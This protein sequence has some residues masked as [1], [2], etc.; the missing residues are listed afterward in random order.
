ML[1]GYF[2]SLKEGWVVDSILPH[3]DEHSPQWKRISD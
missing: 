1:Q 2:F 3:Q